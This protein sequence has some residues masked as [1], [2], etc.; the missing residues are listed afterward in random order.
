MPPAKTQIQNPT[1]PSKNDVGRKYVVE[2]KMTFTQIE[3]GI[4]IA[5]KEIE[6]RLNEMNAA[7]YDLAGTIQAEPYLVFFIY[8]RR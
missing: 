8:K 4:N 1:T 3:D 7:G 5:P 6:K 2:S